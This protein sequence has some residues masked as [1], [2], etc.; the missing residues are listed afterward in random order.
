MVL[1]LY[2][3][4][5]QRGELQVE[6]IKSK[7]EQAREA[8]KTGDLNKEY[9]F[10][11]LQ[12]VEDMNNLYE[13]EKKTSLTFKTIFN[14]VLNQEKVAIGQ[15]KKIVEDSTAL[16]EKERQE[17]EELISEHKKLQT[18]YIELLRQYSEKEAEFETFKERI[19]DI[20]KMKS[21]VIDS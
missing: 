7:I 12:M 13:E 11:L 2:A 10:K 17:K 3:E 19:K 21:E 1:A 20:D 6:D 16:I 5:K 18:S 15:L 14:D 8:L 4:T 9:Q